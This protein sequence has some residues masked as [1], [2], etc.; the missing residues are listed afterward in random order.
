MPNGQ[1]MHGVIG[2]HGSQVMK[3]I[4][5]LNRKLNIHIGIRVIQQVQAA[6][7]VDGLNIIQHQHGVIMEIGV[8]GVQQVYL[9]V[10]PDRWSRDI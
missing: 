4:I 5:R 2:V 8:I 6:H 1:K 3:I 10:L 7:L 9:V